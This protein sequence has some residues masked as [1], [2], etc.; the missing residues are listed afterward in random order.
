MFI[1]INIFSLIIAVH[2]TNYVLQQP[3]FTDFRASGLT[4]PTQCR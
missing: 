2:K 4:I 3:P 1:I